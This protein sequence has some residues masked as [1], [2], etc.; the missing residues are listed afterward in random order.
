MQWVEELDDVE[1]P[2]RFVAA[3]I[4]H[5]IRGCNW[6]AARCRLDAAR[7]DPNRSLLPVHIRLCEVI[8]EDDIVS[9]QRQKNI[10]MEPPDGNR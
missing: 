10:E 5:L 1:A 9:N 2:H 3:S 4:R 7:R 8:Y 6:A